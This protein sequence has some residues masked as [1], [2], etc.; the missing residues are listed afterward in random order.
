V[1]R[2]STLAT[3]RSH[4]RRKAPTSRMGAKLRS[5]FSPRR[6]NAVRATVLFKRVRLL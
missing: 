6:L 2:F 3:P 5:N 1:S 4:V